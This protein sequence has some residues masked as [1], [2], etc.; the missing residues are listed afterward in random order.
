MSDS[1]L[2]A[3]P[4]FHP[5]IEETSILPEFILE[6]AGYNA[7]QTQNLW[8]E[9]EVYHQDFLHFTVSVF[10][11]S[12]FK[13]LNHPPLNSQIFLDMKGKQE[14]LD[15]NLIKTKETRKINAERLIKFLQSW[16][17]RY[18]FEAEIAAS[19]I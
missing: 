1:Y 5:K 17:I 4:Y 9:F 3:I 15:R 11:F 10:D 12:G 19:H 14:S 8:N 13:G 2:E 7:H 18:W 16:F 6:E